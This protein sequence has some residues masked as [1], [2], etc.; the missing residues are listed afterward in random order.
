ME[1]MHLACEHEKNGTSS[2]I[3]R[4][5]TCG[6]SST[7]AEHN[8]K[9]VFAVWLLS[10]NSIGWQPVNARTQMCAPSK[11]LISGIARWRY[12]RVLHGPDAGPPLAVRQVTDCGENKSP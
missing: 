6:E 7:A 1:A 11:L 8:V 9:F 2:H 12:F 3:H 10:V 4:L 5:P